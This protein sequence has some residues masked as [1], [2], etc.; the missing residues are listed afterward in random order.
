[1]EKAEQSKEEVKTISE[2]EKADKKLPKK[3]TVGKPSIE[4]YKA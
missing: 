1:M 2:K 3:K 4:T